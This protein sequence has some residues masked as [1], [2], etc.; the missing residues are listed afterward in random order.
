VFVQ[1]ISWNDYGECHHIS[2]I[3]G[4]SMAAFEIGESN[5]NYALDYPHDGWREVLPFLIDQYKTGKSSMIDDKVVFWY[6]PNP[7]WTWSLVR[8]LPSKPRQSGNLLYKGDAVNAT[9]R[10]L[11]VSSHCNNGMNNFNAW[12][13]SLTGKF[14]TAGTY[15]TQVDLAGHA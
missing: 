10:G 13:G 3:Y 8:K 15:E 5:Y 2:P 12:V 4:K 14:Q 6:R 7:D 9:A 1:I 11:E